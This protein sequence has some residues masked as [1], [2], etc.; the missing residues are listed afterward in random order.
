MV[1]SSSGLSPKKDLAAR[2]L[3]QGY[4]QVEVARDERVDVTKQTLN[5]W[6]KDEVFQKRV[7]EFRT[8][9]V[10]QAEEVFARN[11]GEA[12][13]A[14]VEIAVGRPA[15][16]DGKAIDHRFIA[17]K[18][19][20]ALFIVDRMMGKKLPPPVKKGIPSLEDEEEEELLDPKDVKDM[21]EYANA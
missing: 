5:N 9:L 19:K 20:A 1:L 13:E 7:E 14:I 11:V 21:I 10:K 17:S 8:D 4:T 2:L 12:A 6:C 16:E 15:D 3:S 18:L